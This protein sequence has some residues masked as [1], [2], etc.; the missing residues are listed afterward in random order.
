MNAAAD[1]VARFEYQRFSPCA[2]QSPSSRQPCD[3]RTN[4]ERFRFVRH[5]AL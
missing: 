5:V 4:D 2:R 1:A 3:P